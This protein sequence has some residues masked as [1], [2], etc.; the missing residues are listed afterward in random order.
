MKELWDQRE[1]Q[2]DYAYG[3]KPNAF[4][5]QQIDDLTPGK[6]LLPAEG[7]GRNA[8]Y[9]A[10]KGWD[11]FAF[12]ISIEGKKKA[13]QLA[14][15]MG[16]EISYEVGEYDNLDYGEDLFDLVAIIFAHVDPRLR[17]GFHHTMAEQLKP[18]GKIILEGFSK[19][20]ITRTTGGPKNPDMLFSNDE[21]KRDFS[22]LSRIKI[23]ERE[24]LLNEG[25]YHQ[26]LAAIIRATGTK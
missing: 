25:H 23:W 22:N 19:D 1:A 14:E 7:E 6:L 18:G 13:L 21:L 20:Q 4:F 12:D 3:T 26:G 15:R 9:A 16:V 5:K 10:A 8:A 11:V 24:V 2:I 17:A